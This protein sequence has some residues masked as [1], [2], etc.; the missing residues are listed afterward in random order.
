[1]KRKVTLTKTID[2]DEKTCGSC[3]EC[4]WGCM[5]FSTKDGQSRKL[6]ENKD[7]VA[8]RCKQCLDAEAAAKA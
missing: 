3:G 5:L 6:K 2:C 1:M 7:G 8:L 4:N